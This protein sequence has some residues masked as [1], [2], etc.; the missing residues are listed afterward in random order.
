MDFIRRNKHGSVKEFFVFFETSWWWLKMIV[1]N[2]IPKGW[3]LQNIIQNGLQPKDVNNRGYWSIL[4][5]QCIFELT[6]KLENKSYN[7]YMG[8]YIH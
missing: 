2:I 1:K 6:A 3:E 4:I 5:K 7:R 8:R